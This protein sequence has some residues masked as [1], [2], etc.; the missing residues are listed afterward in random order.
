[1]GAGTGVL[2][3]VATGDG[4]ADTVGDGDLVAMA[5]TVDVG[6]TVGCDVGA[7]GTCVG[8]GVGFFVGFGV[9]LGVGFGVGFGV[10]AGGLGVGPARTLTVRVMVP[11][12]IVQTALNVPGWLKR[13]SQVHS[14]CVGSP[15]HAARSSQSMSWS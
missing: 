9:G 8:G 7:G 10:A 11:A 3:G 5:V 4:D 15:G 14:F 13:R 6:T 1:M 2:A 12:W